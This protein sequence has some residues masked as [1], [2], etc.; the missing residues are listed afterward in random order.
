[1]QTHNDPSGPGGQV[2]APVFLTLRRLIRR[3][4]WMLLWRG[5]CVVVAVTVGVLLLLMGADATLGL[6]AVWVR[7]G[8][9]LLLYGAV[10]T[11]AWIYLVRPLA[12]SFTL[13]GMAR[14]VEKRHPEFHEILSSAVELLT[15]TDSPEL[16]GSERLVQAVVEGA[17]R[18]AGRVRPEKELSLRNLRAYLAV[19]AFTLALLAT[20]FLIR[21]RE[22]AFLIT[23]ASA[24][25]LNVP[26][27]RALD[28]DVRPGD[29]VVAVGKALQIQV[30]PRRRGRPK[31]VVLDLFPTDGTPTTVSMKADVEHGRS[32]Y[33]WT[34]QPLLAGFVYRVRADRAVSRFYRVRVEAP[35]AV[36]RIRIAFE[37]PAYTGR[38]PG[39]EDDAPG[40]IRALAGTRVR[41]GIRAGKPLQTA[42]LRINGA[43]APSVE[44]RPGPDSNAWEF[45]WTLVPEMTGAWT[46]ALFDRDGLEGLSRPHALEVATDA[47]PT[48]RVEVPTQQELKLPPWGALPIRFV[49][50]DDCGLAALHLRVRGGGRLLAEVPIVLPAGDRGDGPVRFYRGQCSL[51]LS[52]LKL[53]ELRRVTF[54][55]RVRDTLPHGA[56]GPQTGTS[57]IFRID[58][59]RSAPDYVQQER[60]AGAKALTQ[61]IGA[62]RRELSGARDSVQKA[63][64]AMEKERQLAPET[65][66]RLEAARKR[67]DAASRTLEKALQAATTPLFKAPADELRKL[68]RESLQQTARKL[69][70]TA[71]EPNHA[72]AQELAR[73]ATGDLWRAQQDLKKVQ[74]DIQR[75]ARAARRAEVVQALAQ[76]QT[77]LTAR[78]LGL[79]GVPERVRA[80]SEKAWRQAQTSVA[81]RLAQMIAPEEKLA[82]TLIA[83]DREAARDLAANVRRLADDQEGLAQA[84]SR[85]ALRPAEARRMQELARRQ[86]AL[87][88]QAALRPD[89]AAAAPPMQA[90][91]RRLAEGRPEKALERQEQARQVLEKAGA[92]AGRDRRPVQ[93]AQSQPPAGERIPQSE[94]DL[95]QL[96]AAQAELARETGALARVEQ[97]ARDAQRERLLR[98]LARVQDALARQMK[99]LAGE[100]PDVVPARRA[101]Q[102]AEQ[103]AR[104]AEALKK[105]AVEE[106]A[107]AARQA[108][109]AMA[110][111]RQ[112]LAAAA[113]QPFRPAVSSA[114]AGS[115]RAPVPGEQTPASTAEAGASQQ[116][117]AAPAVPDGADASRAGRK[118]PPAPASAPEKGEQAAALAQR[119][120]ELAA[121][122]GQVAR[123]IQQ[124]AQGAADEALAQQQALAAARTAAAARRAR[125]LQEHARLLKMTPNGAEAVRSLD[126]ARQA[127]TAAAQSLADAAASGRSVPAVPSAPA[128]GD[129]SPTQRGNGTGRS[130]RV[131]A[132][133]AAAA[134]DLREAAKALEA[135]AR[136]ERLGAE[137]AVPSGAP[138]SAPAGGANPALARAFRAAGKSANNGAPESAAEAAFALQ[139]AAAQAAARVKD[140]GGRLEPH[141]GQAPGPDS[142]EG[143]DEQ[144]VQAPPPEVRRL[145]I[146]AT[147]WGRL[148]GELRTQILEAGLRNMPS[149]Y[150]ELI[151]SYFRELARRTARNGTDLRP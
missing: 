2:P 97:V 74:D 70:D 137:Q 100:T 28:L 12:R 41:L 65:A 90:A 148:P 110:Q 15:S 119:A 104:A 7:W 62:A 19:T 4:R 94:Q 52:A 111:T 114:P 18:E 122:Q 49:A 151:R 150:R 56:G 116:A 63:A 33:V 144:V 13:T 14:V 103:A 126:S 8:L 83:V 11:A 109:Q 42:V 146:S 6:Y 22:T 54:R 36:E 136:A 106:A 123:A 16:R 31:R 27:L 141:S 112:T 26:N 66:A 50:E 81:R 101:G 88:A 102:A 72:Q 3:A 25:F 44:S 80:V 95:A 10:G 60:T 96:S 51:A 91:A 149:E 17:A 47:R 57:K 113:L 23:R 143:V 9:S 29:V 135:F 99:E 20:L 120:G 145:G 128:L 138:S 127:A 129:R 73:Q 58:I 115:K 130:S 117:D 89:A 98:N 48:V 132:R 133:Q 61:G 107:R 21:P 43:I 37:Y 121:E 5:V 140:L 69:A 30:R 134:R 34:S 35:P 78:R 142:R 39:V 46:V 71:V 105:P 53:G 38:S 139:T 82:A 131:Q 40:A 92:A 125:Q 64:R 86:Q 76:T 75:L 45:V 77:E 1:M 118:R 55:L 108:A 68:A 59:Q 67:I 79:D 124:M 147:D 32:R 93:Q 24:P 87:A 85:Q 84:A